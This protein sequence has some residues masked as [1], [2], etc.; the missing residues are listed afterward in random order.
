MR[1]DSVTIKR[2]TL[3]ELDQLIQAGDAAAAREVIREA[4]D[5]FRQSELQRCKDAAYQKFRAGEFSYRQYRDIWEYAD[6][7]QR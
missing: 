6:G 3:R 5:D 2:A 4:L 1:R 7:F